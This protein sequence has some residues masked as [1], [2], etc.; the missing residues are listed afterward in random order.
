MRIGKAALAAVLILPA[1]ALL[2]SCMDESV[3]STSDTHVCVFD[4]SD[5]G[6][7]KLKFQIPPGAEPKKVDDNDQV[8]YIPASNRFYMATADDNLRDPL[9]PHDY[10][11]NAENNVPVKVEGQVRFK[12]NLA[13]ACEWYSKHGRRNANENGDLEFNARGDGADQS[14]WLRYLAENFGTT[15]NSVV[16]Q[17]T[18]QHNWASMYYN[19]PAN[20]NDAGVVPDGKTAGE[21]TKLVVGRELGIAFTKQL[22][23][24]LGGNYF[25]GIE[26]SADECPP[27]TFQVVRIFPTNDQLIASRSQLES[28]K[29]SLESTRLEG[30]LQR[31]QAAQVEAA[32]AAK[33]QIL[34]AQ[35]ETARIEAEI[36]NVKCLQL[37]ELG[38]DCEGK[39]PAPIIGN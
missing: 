25:C 37:A 4:G 26:E 34:R 17:V 2:A 14:G 19:Y 13:R 33:Q 30:Q 36:A 32:E 6:G 16:Q 11:S 10:L 1:S 39:R 5:D 27:M 21:P 38:L 15:M 12:F 23:S 20:A 28:T 18:S 22:N 24:N 31:E 35:L 29:E 9:A 3:S 7:Q 8:V